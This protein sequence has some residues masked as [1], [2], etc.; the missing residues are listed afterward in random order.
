MSSL[1]TSKFG[2]LLLYPNTGSFTGLLHNVSCSPGI[3]WSL[4]SQLL[5]LFSQFVGPRMRVT[6]TCFSI[7]PSPIY[8]CS[9]L[10][11]AWGD[12]Y[13]LQNL[14]SGKL[15]YMKL[16]LPS[17][18]MLP[19]LFILQATVYSVWVNRNSCIFVKVCSSI[20]SSFSHIQMLIRCK[21]SMYRKRITTIE[22]RDLYYR[23]L[24][25]ECCPQLRYLCTVVEWANI[26]IPS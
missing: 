17:S 11:I 26:W 7:V 9:K 19:S 2:V 22:D 20:D 10:V 4:F 5:R 15:G 18:W 8:F 3:L 25:Q 14:C 1:F 24:V 21:I 16:N 12:L 23:L 6:S 13:F